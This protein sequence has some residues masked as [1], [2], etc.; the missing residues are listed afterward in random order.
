MRSGRNAWLSASPFPRDNL[1]AVI[2]DAAVVIQDQEY[3]R[4]A[5]NV[6]ACPWHSPLQTG[7]PVGVEVASALGE[8]NLVVSIDRAHPD[9]SLTR[10]R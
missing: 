5:A 4:V 7:R 9:L 10:T 3:D 2:D 1:S 8:L 6:D